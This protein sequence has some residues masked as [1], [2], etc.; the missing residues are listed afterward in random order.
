MRKLPDD[1]QLDL[2]DESLL[3]ELSLSRPKAQLGIAEW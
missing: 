3:E 2:L 1:G